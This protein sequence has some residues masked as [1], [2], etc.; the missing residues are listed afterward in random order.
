ME[1]KVITQDRDLLSEISELQIKKIE[2]YLGVYTSILR[3]LSVE[4]PKIDHICPN[5]VLTYI[6]TILILFRH[7]EK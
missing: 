6:L 1:G 3:N 2:V 5:L 4:T 7:H